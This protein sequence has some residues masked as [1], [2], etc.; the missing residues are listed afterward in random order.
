MMRCFARLSGPGTVT[1]ASVVMDRDTD[2]SR[3]FGF[4]TMES[5]RDGADRDQAMDS[6]VLDGRTIPRQCRP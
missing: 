3:G 1:Q 2:R 5:R 6:T 4:V